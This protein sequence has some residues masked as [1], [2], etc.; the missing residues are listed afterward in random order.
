MQ[1]LTP[2]DWIPIVIS[3]VAAGVSVF[4]MWQ[5]ARRYKMDTYP[6]IV[7][8]CEVFDEAPTS[9]LGTMEHA[10]LRSIRCEVTNYSS[11]V[12]IVDIRTIMAVRLART[13]YANESDKWVIVDEKKRTVI[14]EFDGTQAYRNTIS[15][16]LGDRLLPKAF[17]DLFPNDVELLET[18][19][20]T[21]KIVV[22]PSSIFDIGLAVEYKIGLYGI[23]KQLTESRIFRL[24]ASDK[25]GLEWRA[26]TISGQIN[27][28]RL[29]KKWIPSK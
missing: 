28:H 9:P 2:I 14:S 16:G 3:L 25:D 21:E 13:L 23:D 1:Q 5:N 15:V 12:S 27:I 20:G 17:K 19:L 29:K 6:L 24:R 10:G 22:K 7:L 4:S 8:R 26:D 11:K 18:D